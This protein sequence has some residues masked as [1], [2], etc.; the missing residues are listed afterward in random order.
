MSEPWAQVIFESI[1]DGV[2]LAGPDW[3]VRTINP[4]GEQLLGVPR[5]E[6]VDRLLARAVRRGG[7]R[8][9]EASHEARPPR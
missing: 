7:S 3:C 1:S 5:N 6:I 8:E 2:L 9:S 4:A